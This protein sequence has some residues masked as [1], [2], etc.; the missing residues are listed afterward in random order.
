MSFTKGRTWIDDRRAEIQAELDALEDLE[1]PRSALFTQSASRITDRAVSLAEGVTDPDTVKPQ[2]TLLVKAMLEE[3]FPAGLPDESPI[4]GTNSSKQFL[5]EALVLLGLALKTDP[6]AAVRGLLK[7]PIEA[8]S[9]A[10]AAGLETVTTLQSVLTQVA[11]EPVG[12][13]ISLRA[14]D[15]RLDSLE[16][17]LGQARDGIERILANLSGQQAVNPLLSQ[18]VQAFLASSMDSLT[19]GTGSLDRLDQLTQGLTDGLLSTLQD[20]ENIIQSL[21]ANL[22]SFRGGY[23]ATATGLYADRAQ[24]T[25]LLTQVTRLQETVSG[26]REREPEVASFRPAW[27]NTL[28]TLLALTRESRTV[29]TQNIFNEDTD[30]ATDYQTLVDAL[31]I[32]PTT[33]LSGLTLSMMSIRGLLLGLS[34]GTGFQEQYAE[35]LLRAQDLLTIYRDRLNTVQT[36]VNT[37]PVTTSPLLERLLSIVKD[38]KM[39]FA[40]DALEQG[41]IQAFMNLSVGDLNPTDAISKEITAFLGEDADLTA[42]LGKD[43]SD[44]LG[45]ILAFE[46]NDIQAAQGFEDSRKNAIAALKAD[47]VNL[48]RIESVF[49]KAEA[50]KV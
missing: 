46:S 1:T 28:L 35:T 40:Q 44:S 24:V 43:L 27:L 3:A 42:T 25:A 47:L 16:L 6:G 33:D 23:E 13:G 32:V 12:Q 39:K 2:L 26:V 19:A 50:Q 18:Q 22:A 8:L 11:E 49:D 14:E 48:D 45:L 29:A 10:V 17:G 15:P 38:S 9:R 31:A 30:L 20:N 34:T 37:Y 21:R 7:A 5:S 4:S 36:I 41:D